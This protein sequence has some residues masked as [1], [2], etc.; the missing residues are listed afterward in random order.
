M[1]LRSARAAA[2]SRL[3]QV[4]VA[5]RATTCAL[6]LLLVRSWFRRARKLDVLEERELAMR[7]F[8]QFDTN[9]NGSL[10]ADEFKVRQL[11]F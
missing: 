3:E 4:R 11:S 1:A 6:I 7:A 9:G 10:D 2:E 8:A 5:R